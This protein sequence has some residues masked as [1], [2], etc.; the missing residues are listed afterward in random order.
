MKLSMVVSPKG[1]MGQM[2]VSGIQSRPW[3]KKAPNQ[4]YQKSVFTSWIF[5]NVYQVQREK[6][7]FITPTAPRT[8]MARFP[9]FFAAM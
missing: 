3:T 8:L 5:R 4:A 9:A 6:T 2:T 7:E 1:Q